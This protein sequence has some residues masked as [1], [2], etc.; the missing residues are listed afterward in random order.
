MRNQDDELIRFHGRDHGTTVHR[1]RLHGHGP[2]LAVLAI[3]CLPGPIAGI[4]QQEPGREG[5]RDQEQND[6][7]QGSL[8]HGVRRNNSFSREYR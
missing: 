3:G 7:E 2:G 6:S 1:G 4:R 5:G 8:T